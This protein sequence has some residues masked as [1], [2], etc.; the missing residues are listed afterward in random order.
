MSNDS[1]VRALRQL[2]ALPTIDIE[3]V[4]SLAMQNLMLWL[5]SLVMVPSALLASSVEDLADGICIRDV[6][7]ALQQRW[8]A[9]DVAASNS[10]IIGLEDA[11]QVCM[12]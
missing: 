2:E 4:V 6:T 8:G 3:R 7:K 1:Q 9:V 10:R 5:N 12:A 11:L